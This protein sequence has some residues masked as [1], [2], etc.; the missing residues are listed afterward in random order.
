MSKNKKRTMEEVRNEIEKKY[1]GK[2]EILSTEYINNKQPLLVRCND[3]GYE[4]SI[5]FNKLSID[6]M[7]PKCSRKLKKTTETF[8][9][10]VKELTND[11]FEVLSEYI[12][13]S[14][15]IKMRHK[16][17]GYEWFVIPKN[18]TSVKTSCPQCSHQSVKYTFENFMKFFNIVNPDFTLQEIYINNTKY[19]SAI[20]NNCNTEIKRNMYY[21]LKNEIICPTCFNKESVGVKIIKKI[22]NELNFDYDSEYF[23]KGLYS[24]RGFAMKMDFSIKELNLFIEFDGPQHFSGGYFSKNNDYLRE[25]DLLKNG[26]I[27]EIKSSLIRIDYDS[28]KTKIA[29]EK[30]ILLL[31]NILTNSR[32]STTNFSIKFISSGEECT[33]EYYYRNCRSK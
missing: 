8:K 22:L 10:E 20:C 31:T 21:S 16:E 27:R 13:T 3:C 24:P 4:R 2:I 1:N 19:L 9:E 33:E 25:C 5:S 12:N 14:T 28:I 6:S 17:C 11:K 15:K 29:R 26:L 18:F 7:C 30:T 23:F 32:S